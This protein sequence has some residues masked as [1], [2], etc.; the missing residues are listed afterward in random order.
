MIPDSAGLRTL[1][2]AAFA[3]NDNADAWSYL[4][5]LERQRKTDFREIEFE[6]FIP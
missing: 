2:K 5:W 6:R 3:I 4:P 1:Q